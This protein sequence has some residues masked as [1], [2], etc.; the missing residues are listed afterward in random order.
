MAAIWTSTYTYTDA[1]NLASS[2]YGRQ[3]EPNNLEFVTN[4]AIEKMWR[5]YD[6][7]GTLKPLP[8]FWLV[9]GQQDYG[10]PFYSV[11]SNYYGLREA[12]LVSINSSNPI[13]RK[14][15]V[16]K[17]VEKTSGMGWPTSIFYQD[18][19]AGYRIWPCPDFGMSSPLFLIDGTYKIRPPKITRALLGSNLLWDDLYFE[20]FVQACAWAMLNWS[21]GGKKAAQ[22]QEVIF[23]QSLA[24]ATSDESLEQ[25][26]AI[27][28]PA[29][30]LIVPGGMMGMGYGPWGGGL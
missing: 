21:P 30:P 1:W 9:P 19:I 24:R 18:T 23:M 4:Q 3:N 6:W 13:R 22:E 17:G 28:H 12:Y 25:G 11:P 14:L 15:N 5:S 8:P 10:V 16:T 26:E 7:R 2:Q 27:I 20:T 29:E